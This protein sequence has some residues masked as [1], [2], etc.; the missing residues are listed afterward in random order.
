[1]RRREVMLGLGALAAA[2]SV[3]VAVRKSAEKNAGAVPAEPDL[4]LA[5]I[6]DLVIPDTD[7]PGARR[8]GVPQFL[9]IAMQHGLAGA[10]SS[11]HAQL[12]RMLDA[13]AGGTFLTLDHDRQLAVLGEV[14]RQAWT[15][16]GSLWA[17]V[18]KL[19]LMGYYTSEIGASQELQY[20]LVPGRFDPDLPVHPG[21]RAWSSDWVGQGF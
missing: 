14:D 4:L 9:T 21:D 5:R 3:W 20:Q 11:D 2:G 17:R 6:C 8:A 18:K 15:A 19:V 1:M 16:P 12:G 13:A 10:T 7:T